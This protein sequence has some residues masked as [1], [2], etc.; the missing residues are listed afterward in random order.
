MKHTKGRQKIEMMKVEAY[1][2]RMAT[3][4]KRK[5]GIFKKMNEMITQCNV[6]MAFMVFTET[7]KLYTFANPSVEEALGRLKSP[8]T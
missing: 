5:S 7:G 3:F 1:R 8:S 4:S 6:E 2:D